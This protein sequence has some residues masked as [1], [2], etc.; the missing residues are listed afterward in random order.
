MLHHYIFFVTTTT[1][2]SNMHTQTQ[3]PIS[4]ELGQICYVAYMIVVVLSTTTDTA[5]DLRILYLRV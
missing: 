4:N 3:Q 5:D 1:S 2:Y